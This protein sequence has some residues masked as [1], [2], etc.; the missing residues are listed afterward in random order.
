[1]DRLACE[2]GGIKARNPVFLAA[3]TCGYLDEMADVLDLSRIGGL[4]MKS[5]TPQPREGNPTWR[6]IESR[7]GMLNAIGL[8]NVGLDHFLEHIAPRIPSIPCAIVASIA[9]FSI[10]DYIR[11][12][13]AVDEVPGLAAVELNVSCPN[14][15]DGLEFGS[16]P[17]L[18]RELIGAVRG[19]ITRVP[20]WV[21]LTPIAAGAPGSTMLD[22]ARAAI[23]G[24]GRASPGRPG[25]DALCLCNTF[26]AMAIDVRTR[27]PR[28]ANNTGGLSG[29][30]I[31]PIV[32][33]IIH[34][35]HRGIAREHA[36]PII[37]IGG[38][39]A[40][41][42]AAEFI[43]AGAAGIQIGTSLF[44]DPATPLRV[45]RGLDRWVMRQG[46]AS[47]NELV[48]TVERH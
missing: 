43:L 25:A 5:I 10:A 26:P 22:M 36:V 15:R 48:G 9:G 20:L 39:L 47:I 6:I 30:A 32:V 11:T 4:V 45:A 7:A 34:D 33:K 24:V 46:K 41:Q 12:A 3:G 16:D 40:W 1:M 42:D 14:V 8:A 21:K 35:I 28:L 31:H 23:E 2:V 17:R 27:R 38:V 13:S 29:P 19:C 44:A 18:L 37:G